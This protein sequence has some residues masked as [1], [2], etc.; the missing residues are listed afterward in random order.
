MM[1]CDNVKKV[2][3]YH[4]LFLWFFADE[5]IS[6]FDHEAGIHTAYRY[7]VAF[8]KVYILDER[9]IPTANTIKFEYKLKD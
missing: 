8:G 3:W 1:Y 4:Y 6:E 5:Y 9:V 2:M 7:K